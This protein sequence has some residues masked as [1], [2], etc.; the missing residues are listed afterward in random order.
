MILSRPLA[1]L[2]PIAA[3]LLLLPTA[4][5]LAQT[6]ARIVITPTNPRVV[7]RD[8]LRLKAEAV[9][10]AGKP[11]PNAT[12]RFFSGGTE[13]EGRVDSTGLIR[14][15]SVGTLPV[16]VSALVPGS[17]PVVQRLAIQMVPG[18]ATTVEIPYAPSKLLVGQRQPVHAIA[19][20]SA[21]D[22]SA[23]RLRWSSSAPA[24]VRVGEDGILVA[25]GEGKAKITVGA[26]SA[27]KTFDVSVVAV[28]GGN[29]TLTPVSMQARQ[30]DVVRFSALVKD[31]SGA[32][33]QGV[34]PA[35]SFAPGGGEITPDGAFVGYDPG[36]YAVTAS[37][38]RLTATA[39]VTLTERNVR[40]KP[41]VVGAVTRSAFLT[42]E[43]WVHPNGKVAYLGTAEGGDRFYVLDISDPAKPV[44]ADSV[45]DNFRIVND[46]MTDEKGEVLVFTREGAD[47]RKNGIVIC[48]LADPLHPKKVADFT[49]DVTSGVHSAFIYTDPK[50]GR[51]VYL[52]NDATGALHIINIDDPAKPH[53]VARWKTPRPE[54]GRMLHDIDVQ[55]GL[56]YGSWWNDGLVILDVGN[57]VK[58]G[59]P[60][61]PQFVSQYKYDLD[62]LYR[63]RVEL[64]SGAGYIRGTHTAWR[65]G[66][67]VFI[68][69]EVFGIDQ[70]MAALGGRVG[71]AYGRLQALDVSDIEHPKSVA[72]YEPEFGGVHNVWVAGDTLYVGAYNA[73]FH[74][75]DI[76]GELRGN[77]QAQGR[78]ITHFQ[79]MSPKGLIPNASMTWGVVVKN[80]LA[81]VNDMNSGL[82]IVKLEPK[83]KVVP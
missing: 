2:V 13:F 1:R 62:A 45:I 68:A 78:E 5:A 79:P 50:H 43:V 9:D 80:N 70:V 35:W 46:I 23:E 19:R 83:E 12:I 17:R 6:V 37:F 58:G 14:S 66:K 77:L 31:A 28:N 57:G 72:W 32:T 25:N 27:A 64:E 74:A 71:R 49:D 30:G 26:G 40:R 41:M 51:H 24:V 47:N 10:S 21:G 52:T 76:S 48:T 22:I 82:W 15:G 3:A 11:V 39:N 75:F 63:S 60:S 61:N 65:H 53:E 18:P 4:S 69:D 67:Y 34:Q 8:T 73:G 36:T 42:S 54:A 20:S 38:G 33:V 29:V 16:V 59:T 81:F 55:D 56:V 7:A 44:V